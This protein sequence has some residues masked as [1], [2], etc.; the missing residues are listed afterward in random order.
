MKK[1]ISIFLA[2][3]AVTASLN[4]ESYLNEGKG[5]LIILQQD[6]KGIPYNYKGLASQNIK[7]V[8]KTKVNG[9]NYNIIFTDSKI[10]IVNGNVTLADPKDNGVQS[11]F[12]APEDYEDNV[13]YEPPRV[14]NLIYHNLGDDS[15]SFCGVRVT[16]DVYDEEKREHGILKSEIIIPDEA[17]Q[18]ILDLIS[19]YTTFKNKTHIRFLETTRD[20]PYPNSYEKSHK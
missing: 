18:E 16:E 3:L 15:K 13:A 11:V 7:K 5:E 17:A 2:S 19:N 1:F 4:A 14:I 10:M 20:T 9:K 12:I 8:I 6:K